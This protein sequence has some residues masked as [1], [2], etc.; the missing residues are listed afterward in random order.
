MTKGIK[1]ILTVLPILCLG[2]ITDEQKV[3]ID[4]LFQKWD[5]ENYPGGVVGV[6]QSDTISY[7][8]AFGNASL[9]YDVPNTSKT[10]FNIGSVSKQFTA[11]GIVVLHQQGLLSIDER[12]EKYF[13]DFPIFKTP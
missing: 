6:I 12:V 7:L 3:R 10:M 11:M 8:N 1:M 9:E 2:Q 4:S 5:L 13:P